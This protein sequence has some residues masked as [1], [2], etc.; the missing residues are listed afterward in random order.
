M[1]AV[2]QEERTRRVLPVRYTQ[3]QWEQKAS[4]LADKSKA[5]DR[6]E[7]EAKAVASGYKERIKALDTD[8]RMLATQV[9]ER[10]EMVN[11]E[12]VV[13]FDTPEYGKKQIIRTDS[14]EVA[15]IETMTPDDRQTVMFHQE[16][17]AE[18][19]TTAPADED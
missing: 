7:D 15:L 17:A 6:M 9:A 8:R 1:V 3:E 12:C 5:L 16:E 10:Q 2:V 14:G 19:E 13:H 18:P 11:V 4:E